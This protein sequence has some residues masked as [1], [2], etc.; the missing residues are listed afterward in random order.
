MLYL[1]IF[2]TNLTQLCADAAAPPGDGTGAERLAGLSVGRVSG[3][4]VC[5]SWGWAQLG[6]TQ[7]FPVSESLLGEIHSDSDTELR[8]SEHV[9]G[10]IR[11][12]S[13]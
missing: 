6:Q 2:G 10:V 3:A 1:F 4:G 13:K 8:C 5:Q 9:P 11:L 12:I 7:G